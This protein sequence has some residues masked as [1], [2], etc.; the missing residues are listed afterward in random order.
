M[1][2]LIYQKLDIFVQ[3]SNETLV[4]FLVLISSFRASLVF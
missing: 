3:R 4:H 1:F 2:H